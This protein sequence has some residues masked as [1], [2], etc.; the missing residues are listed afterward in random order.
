[1]VICVQLP[2]AKSNC[3]SVTELRNGNNDLHETTVAETNESSTNAREDTDKTTNYETPKSL[4]Y[5]NLQCDRYRLQ[6]LLHSLQDIGNRNLVAT[7]YT[8]GLKHDLHR[9]CR[10]IDDTVPSHCCIPR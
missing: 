2:V 9:L 1:V 5:L 3:E 8:I 10:I 7:L 4:V 6:C